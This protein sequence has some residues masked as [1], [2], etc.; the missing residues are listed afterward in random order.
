MNIFI[1]YIDINAIKKNIILLCNLI[2]NINF[3]IQIIIYNGYIIHCYFI[4]ITTN[5]LVHND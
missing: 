3:V 2:I 1:K 4:L 5:C